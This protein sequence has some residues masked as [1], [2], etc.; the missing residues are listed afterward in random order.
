MIKPVFPFVGSAY[1]GEGVK[2]CTNYG[3]REK[4]KISFTGTPTNGVIIQKRK[5]RQ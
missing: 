4:I 3:T 5:Y 1:F 2:V